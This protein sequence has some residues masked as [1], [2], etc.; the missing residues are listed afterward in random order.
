M[1]NASH[2]ATCFETLTADLEDRDALGF[3]QVQDLWGRYELYQKSKQKA[4][5]VGNQHSEDGEEL[6]GDEG[7]AEG[8]EEDDGLDIIHA[9]PERRPATRSTLQIPCISRLQAVSPA[10]ASSLSS[11]SSSLSTTSSSAALNGNS[12]SSSNSS[13]FSFG[14]SKQPSPAVPKVE[15]HPLFITWNTISQRTGNKNLRGCIGTFDSQELSSGLGSYALTA[16]FNDSRFPPIGASELY[17]LSC[18]VTLLMNFTTCSSPFDWTLGVHGI[19]IS[20]SHHNR[21]YGSTYLPDVATE[22][23]WTKEDTLASLM[24]K[25]GWSGRSREWREVF[26]KGK[27]TVVRY[28]GSKATLKWDEWARWREWMRSVATT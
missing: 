28:E 10:S 4:S 17:S 12:K 19:K 15:E 24:K 5:G 27:G 11:T 22:Q 25:A 21:R 13:F 6:E 20:F 1:A 16:A 26:E 7:A 14:R 18:S 9:E 23:G 8:L 2:C 3:E